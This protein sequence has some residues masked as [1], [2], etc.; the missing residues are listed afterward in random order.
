MTTAGVKQLEQGRVR[1]GAMDAD[2]FPDELSEEPDDQEFPDDDL[3]SVD[4][5]VDC[6]PVDPLL[7]PPDEYPCPFTTRPCGAGGSS[8]R[9]TITTGRPP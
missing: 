4:A 9:D 6:L 8:D 5:D 7:A 1:M 2:E 3:G